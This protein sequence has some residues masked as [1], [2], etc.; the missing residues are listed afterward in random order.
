MRKV[1]FIV[2]AALGHVGRALMVARELRDGEGHG[3]VFTG[4][5]LAGYL[6][7]Y[8][9]PEGFRTIPLRDRD[10]NVSP[11]VFTERVEAVLHEESPDLILFDLS[12]L[13]W[14]SMLRLPDVPVVYL[15]NHF[16]T[17]LG[18]DTTVQDLIFREYVGP[19]NQAR[20]SRGLEPLA[21][22][23]ELYERDLVILAD[24]AGLFDSPAELPSGYV[25]TGAIWW[26]P[27]SVLPA[28]LEAERD[29]LFVSLGSTGVPLPDGLVPE[30]KRVLDISRAVKVPAGGGKGSSGVGV[31]WTAYA[32]LPGTEVLWRSKLCLSQGGAGSSYQALAAGVPLACWPGHL[33]HVVLAKRLEEIGAGV[34][35]EAASWRDRLVSLRDE[36]P[37]MRGAAER[38]RGMSS[39][40]AARVAAS[41]IAALG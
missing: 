26:E 11:A 24:P 20:E 35:L 2:G 1:L 18:S 10:I 21:G 14:L 23:R 7:R 22:A 4:S 25:V 15:T 28:E 40:D 6:E 33:N 27:D 41:R 39:V 30:L 19:I 13:P 12:P 37:A 3:C 34:L 32:S 8:V 36:W 29:L 17:R 31:P 9:A 38:F 16:L 5:D